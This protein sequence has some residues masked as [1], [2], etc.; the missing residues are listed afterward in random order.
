MV[1]G[2][3]VGPVGRVHDEGGALE[4][5]GADH[6][7]EALRVVGLACGP[8]H[9]VSDGLPAGVALLQGVLRRQQQE[10]GR[11]L[12]PTGWLPGHVC[13]TLAP[14]PTPHPQPGL[15]SG[16]PQPDRDSQYS[17]PHSTAPPPGCRTAA[18]AAAAHTDGR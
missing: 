9:A 14:H 10:A 6:T 13:P 15:S 7:G 18:P 2:D 5:A 4:G 16:C 8:Q 12:A 1:V 3:A 17:S 11:E